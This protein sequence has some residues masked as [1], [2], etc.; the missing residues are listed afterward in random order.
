MHL[1]SYFDKGNEVGVAIDDI[2][3]RRRV[4]QAAA[5]AREDIGMRFID[6]ERVRAAQAYFVQQILGGRDV[7]RAEADSRVVGDLAGH[8]HDA[9]V[10][11]GAPRGATTTE[12][13]FGDA[14]VGDVVTQL[15]RAGQFGVGEVR[16]V[17]D[18][19]Q[20]AR[21]G[22]VE[23]DAA[24]VDDLAARRNVIGAEACRVKKTVFESDHGRVFRQ[25]GCA[26]SA[27]NNR[28]FILA[29][30]LRPVDPAQGGTTGCQVRRGVGT[31]PPLETDAGEAREVG[32]AQYRRTM[33]F[34]RGEKRV[35]RAW[36]ARDRIDVAREAKEY[37]GE[38]CVQRR[39]RVSRRL[40]DMVVRQ[41]P[42]RVVR[43]SE[44]MQRNAVK[45]RL[46][47]FPGGNRVDVIEV[48]DGCAEGPACVEL[49]KRFC[50]QGNMRREVF[51]N[52]SD[53]VTGEPDFRVGMFAMNGVHHIGEQPDSPGFRA[54]QAVWQ[55]LV[56]QEHSRGT[57]VFEQIRVNAR[58]KVGWIEHARI[59]EALHQRAYIL[60]GVG[61]AAFGQSGV[62]AGDPGLRG[63]RGKRR[64]E[65]GQIGT[66]ATRHDAV[67]PE[68]QVRAGGAERCDTH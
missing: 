19:G 50:R 44:H 27:P 38:E 41:A 25:P 49:P 11:R 58:R 13:V 16:S 40:W 61:C 66:G 63:A 21:T 9:L 55:R 48:C 51:P 10:A 31:L 36:I 46:Q 37:S 64:G 67:R 1:V 62:D 18:G 57:G 4:D 43:G 5:I 20:I 52:A 59:A 35:E 28:V 68:M 47:A 53:A 30:L 7:L 2:G 12:V 34:D 15:A 22:R 42:P 29:R 32:E 65:P 33:S 17:E 39:L 23:V 54:A 3:E 6:D 45:Q 24:P 14:Q 8:Q 60:R 56:D 26:T